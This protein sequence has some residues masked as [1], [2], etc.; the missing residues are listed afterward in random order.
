[1]SGEVGTGRQRRSPRAPDGEGKVLTKFEQLRLAAEEVAAV[2]HGVDPEMAAKAERLADRLGR[3]RFRVMVVGE[4]NRGKS[5]L[6]NAL[7]GE[8]LLPTGVVPVTSVVTEVGYGP[9]DITARY[10]DGRV[11]TALELDDLERLVSEELNPR[12]GMGVV[13]VEVRVE[14]PLLASG[15]VLVDTPGV[16]SVYAHNDR[17]AASAAGEADAAIVVLSADAALSRRDQ[18]MLAEFEKRRVPCYLVV[19]KADHAEPGDVESIRW[20][21]HKAIDQDGLTVAGMWVLAARP[22]LRA[23]LLGQLPGS[24][25]GA[26]LSFEAELRRF[27]EDQLAWARD[28]AARRELARIC[29]ALVTSLQ[30]TAATLALDAEQISANLA[31]FS[32]AA[33]EQRQA[34][35]D[36][37][38]LLRRDAE[39]LARRLEANLVGFAHRAPERWQSALAEVAATAGRSDLESEL[40]AE[41]VRAVERDFEAFRRQEEGFAEQSWGDAAERARARV[42]IRLDSL[43]SRAA[44]LFAVELPEVRLPALAEEEDRFFYLFV[45]VG[46]STEPWGRLVRWLL[47]ASVVRRRLLAR[48]R[49]QLV[50]EFDKCAGRARHDLT[51]RLER[52]RS[53]FEAALA[54]EVDVTVDSI[55]RAAERAESLRQLNIEER[56]AHEQRAAEVSA[57]VQT[58]RRLCGSV[59]AP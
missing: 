4:F 3:G 54:V 12:N 33:A 45:Q 20:F 26:F 18:A 36:E 56:T 17:A 28:E 25:A 50:D 21:L 16:S 27:A 29:D 42:L 44:E 52:V 46:S 23:K 59:G 32:T 38:V 24:D 34:L 19:N 6:V 14:C 48:S 47:P 31:A 10:V 41:V 11:D 35:A 2:A 5:T 49:R 51:S 43:R 57:V 13:G 55:V 37:A 58:V 7:V 22:A 15:L 53:R 39:V 30:V 8:N 40:R 1:M 9:R